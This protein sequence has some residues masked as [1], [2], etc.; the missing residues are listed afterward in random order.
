MELYSS[1][2]INKDVTNPGYHYGETRAR[3]P[4]PPGGHDPEVMQG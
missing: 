4:S 1:D 2:K 3:G